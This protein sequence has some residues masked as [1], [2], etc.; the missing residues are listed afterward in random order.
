MDWVIGGAT[1]LGFDD[2]GRTGRDRPRTRISL[3]CPGGCLPAPHCPGVCP[4][5]LRVRAVSPA[6]HPLS[7][8]AVCP[9]PS[10]IVRGV[11]PESA[12]DE[13]ATPSHHSS[14]ESVLASDSETRD[15]AA[16][17]PETNTDRRVT[18]GEP[19]Y[20]RHIAVTLPSFCC[21]MTVT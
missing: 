9:A 18:V 20:N 6:S 12:G 17:P 21:L 1:R 4:A 8:P 11:T 19:S 5:P 7:G 3:Q 2:L 10:G 14:A 16:A 13:S 15:R